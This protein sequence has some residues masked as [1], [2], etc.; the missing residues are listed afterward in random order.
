MKKQHQKRRTVESEKTAAK[1]KRSKNKTSDGRKNGK[2]YGSKQGQKTIHP[3]Q[4]SQ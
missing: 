2:I 3:D 4:G 1:A